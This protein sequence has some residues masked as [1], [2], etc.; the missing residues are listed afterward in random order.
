MGKHQPYENINIFLITERSF[1]YIMR[2]VQVRKAN[3]P[4]TYRI[5]NM[6]EEI[7]VTV[8]RAWTPYNHLVLDIIGH[9]LYEKAYKQIDEKRNTWKNI[10]SQDQL[11]K[12]FTLIRYSQKDEIIDDEL[13]PY[14]D[15][16]KRFVELEKSYEEFKVQSDTHRFEGD[17]T[18]F[19]Q[20]YRQEKNEIL[21]EIQIFLS[22]F[23]KV[24]DLIFGEAIR[25]FRVKFKIE[26]IIDRYGKFFQNRR[27]QSIKNLISRTSQARFTFEYP[28]R[29]PVFKSIIRNKE[30][31][32][33]IKRVALKKINVANENCFNYEINGDV[34]GI[35]FNTFLGNL[36]C[37]NLLTLNTDWFEE[38]FLKLDGYASAIYR[39]FFVT[40]SGNKVNEL[41]IK[42]LVEYFGF[43]NNSRYPEVI[44]K[45]FED[46]K[47]AG[48]IYEYK[49]QNNDKRFSKGYIEVVKSSKSIQ[50]NS[51]SIQDNS[52]S[53]QE[54][55][56]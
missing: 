50:D 29:V 1:N 48:L 9:E 19:L 39:R 47:N 45:A 52:K 41:P 55:A 37:H 13:K 20:E 34:V 44:Q 42:D 3:Y 22:E 43:L 33:I 14:I 17:E 36:F 53:I 30:K 6:D 25:P 11:K 26:S 49:F 54:N 4:Y 18:E 16:Y 56:K 32:N 8:D 40:R 7:S 24:R 15:K 35:I 23:D 38:D 31:E 10:G 2:L 12:V 28:V 46:I 21:Q 27:G 5:Q 51:K